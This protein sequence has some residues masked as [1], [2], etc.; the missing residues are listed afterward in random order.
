MHA[1][2]GAWSWFLVAHQCALLAMG[3]TDIIFLSGQFPKYGRLVI[4]L[5]PIL[6]QWPSS[7]AR[8]CRWPMGFLR[9]LVIRWHRMQSATYCWALHNT[10]FHRYRSLMHKYIPSPPKR[11]PAGVSQALFRICCWIVLGI[12]NH[13]LFSTVPSSSFSFAHTAISTPSSSSF[14][15]SFGSFALMVICTLSRFGL[16]VMGLRVHRN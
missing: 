4:M 16:R 14:P 8:G 9:W 15:S 5:I 11:P 3:S 2:A 1:K 7:I 6:C 13:P 10:V 12:P